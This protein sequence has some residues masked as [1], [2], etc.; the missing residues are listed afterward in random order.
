ML[1][2]S[3]RPL[4][5][6]R[7]ANRQTP[8]SMRCV[9][10]DLD[11]TL[12]GPG[13]SLLRGEDGAFSHAAVRALEACFRAD[14]EVVIFTGRRQ[15]QAMEDA[16]LIGSSA[17]IFEAGAGLVIDGELEWLTGDYLPAGDETIHDQIAA[18]GAP[19]LLLDSYVGRLEYHEPWHLR[20]DVS[21]LFRGLVDPAEVEARLRTEGIEG[22]R[23]VDNGVVHR[24][25]PALAELPQVRVYH[26]VPASASKAGA[27]ARHMQARGYAPEDCIAI[28]DSRE[29]MG[30]AAAVG[31]FWL[32]G[33][34]LE[35]DPSL[36]EAIADRRNV[37]IAEGRYGAGVY[38][39]VVT[40]LAE[41]A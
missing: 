18:T 30:A 28:G 26:L 7:A 32:V 14:V 20:R 6:R 38:E 2:A 21:H 13:A 8:G 37:R 22:L 33:N 5:T 27:V 31:A 10:V 11:G 4:A 39:A 15:A 41:R 35:K 16:R 1:R 34:A 12:L 17:Y 23:L 9:Y 24:H 25:S 19:A 29:D 3:P 40:T 36:R